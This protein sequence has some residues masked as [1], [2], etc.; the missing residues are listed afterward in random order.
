MAGRRRWGF[1]FKRTS[2]PRLTTSLHAAITLGYARTFV[3]TGALQFGRFGARVEGF[4]SFLWM[5]CCSGLACLCRSPERLLAEAKGLCGALYVLN[6]VILYRLSGRGLSERGRRLV[7][8]RF[9]WSAVSVASVTDGM[10]N[11][12]FVLLHLLVALQMA[13][14]RESGVSWLRAGSLGVTLGMLLMCRPEGV[15][16]LGAWGLAGYW[17]RRSVGSGSGWR[18]C[19]AGIGAAGIGAVFLLWR[20]WYFGAI[21]PNSVAAKLWF[22]YSARLASIPWR[23]VLALT[24]FAVPTVGWALPSMGRG[25]FRAVRVGW[26]ESWDRD[27]FGLT[28]VG[29]FMLYHVYT[30]CHM[31]TVNRTFVAV[32]PF[33]LLGVV[34]ALESSGSLRPRGAAGAYLATFLALQVPF[35]WGYV[36]SGNTVGRVRDLVGPGMAFALRYGTSPPEVALPDVGASLLWWGQEIRLVDMALLNHPAAVAGGFAVVGS[37]LFEGG[38]PDVIETHEPWT[39]LCGI[40]GQPRLAEAYVKVTVDERFYLVHRRCVER[41]ME[42]RDD[43]LRV[44][45]VEALDAETRGSILRRRFTDFVG[46][47]TGVGWPWRYAIRSARGFLETGSNRLSGPSRDE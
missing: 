30:G 34:R 26:G 19:A 29:A 45:V 28:C 47:G 6:C 46:D 36:G 4:S 5:L 15:L 43:D 18:L 39:T 13:R 10:E 9:A 23:A 42:A 11:H 8:A 14:A 25:G 27:R 22:P 1:E 35:F 37:S 38:G 31:G 17:E 32:V 41:M 7:T 12:L 3:E 40:A 20:W 2:S 33:A 16:T 24:L 44:S 21:L